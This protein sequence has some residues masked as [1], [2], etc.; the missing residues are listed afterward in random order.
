M[1]VPVPDDRPETPTLRSRDLSLPVHYSSRGGTTSTSGGPGPLRSDH[2]V[3]RRSLI[4]DVLVD[5]GVPD[6]GAPLLG[7]G[8]GGVHDRVPTGSGPGRL[9]G[10]T[11]GDSRTAGTRCGNTPTREGWS[12]RT[13]RG[14]IGCDA[15]RRGV[16]GVDPERGW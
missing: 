8:R 15:P 2:V 12:D 7:S 13:D 1:S 6:L 14:T 9:G 11:S 4:L 10:G 3:V 5:A 16:F